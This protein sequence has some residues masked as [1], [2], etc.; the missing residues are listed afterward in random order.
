MSKYTILQWNSDAQ[1]II[2]IEYHDRIQCRQCSAE[3]FRVFSA[4]FYPNNFH[5]LLLILLFRILKETSP[6]FRISSLKHHHKHY[7]QFF[8]K[9]RVVRGYPHH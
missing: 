4:Y 1:Q 9:I 2:T 5:I 7:R 8:V 6:H 3:G